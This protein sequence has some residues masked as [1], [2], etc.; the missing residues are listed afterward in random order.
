MARPGSAD[1]ADPGEVFV[2][3][4]VGVAGDQPAAQG[5]GGGTLGREPVELPVEPAGG[6]GGVTEPA[7]AAG[8]GGETGVEGG[9]AGG[10]GVAPF[11]EQVGFDPAGPVDQ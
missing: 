11:P 5:V 6:P 4:P 1:G 3:Q 7:E 10:R 9:A 2:D 8:Q